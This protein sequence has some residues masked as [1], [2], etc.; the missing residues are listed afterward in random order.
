M[1][2]YLCVVVV[3]KLAVSIYKLNKF[4]RLGLFNSRLLGPHKIAH[5]VNHFNTLAP[6]CGAQIHQDVFKLFH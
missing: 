4:C 3:Q 2:Q 6:I 1:C 5:L